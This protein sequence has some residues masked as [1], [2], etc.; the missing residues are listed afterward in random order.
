M[1][2]VLSTEQVS[3]LP[4]RE[5]HSDPI[6]L[7]KGDRLVLEASG[8]GRFYAGL[9]DRRAYHRLSATSGGAFGFEFGTDK[10][11]VTDEITADRSDTFY[12]VIRV[13]VF[14]DRTTIK[15]TIARYRGAGSSLRH[16]PA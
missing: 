15:F 7:A 8:S 14:S 9:F 10:R 5:W 16:E 12:V 2:R 6:V 3:L 4:G 11:Q 13:G 1:R